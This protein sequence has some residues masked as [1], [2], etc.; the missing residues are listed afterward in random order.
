MKNLLL[1]FYLFIFSVGNSQNKSIDSLKLLLKIA[2]EDTNKCILLEK[3]CYKVRSTSPIEA[4]NYANEQLKLARELGYKKNEG[5]ALASI[6]RFYF[7]EG[8]YNKALFYFM[9]CLKIAEQLG[10]KYKI[11]ACYANIASVLGTNKEYEKALFY[12]EKNLEYLKAIKYKPGIAQGY[13]NIGLI[14]KELQNH[15]KALDYYLKSIDLCREIKENYLLQNNYEN[16]GA[17]YEEQDKPDLAIIY[18]DEA[19]KLSYSIEDYFCISSSYLNLGRIYNQLKSYQRSIILLDSS[20][21]YSL[22]SN[23]KETEFNAS[24]L[25]ANSYSGLNN[26]QAESKYLKKAFVLKDSL[27]NAEKSKQISEL[28]I[29]YETEKKEAEIRSLNAQNQMQSLKLEQRNYLLSGLAILFIFFILL[30][31]LLFRQNKLRSE[32]KSMQL[33]QKLLRSQMNPHFIFNALIAIESFI[34][35]NQPKEAG[36]YLSGFARLMRLILENSREEFVPLEKEISTLEYYLNLQKLRFDS[37]FDYSIK[38]DESIDPSTIAI[39][40]ML[41]QPF[42]E[43]SIEHGLKG[44]TAKGKI[45]IAFSLENN[46]LVFTVEDNGVGFEQSVQLKEQNI[47]HKSFA[48]KI[49]NERLHNLGRKSRRKIKLVTED[50]KDDLQNVVGGKVIFSI[51]FQQV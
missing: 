29:R 18:F 45:N 42:I 49:T 19:L 43:N 8:N 38:V 26:I 51:P 15:K 17:L 9:E 12:Y 22:L 41:A 37:T 24:L 11:A 14:Y 39:P 10:N 25:L 6:G 32:Q 48:T 27:F 31:F 23:N 2:R 21:K 7:Q 1:C 5:S 50:I 35:K 13:S 44:N 28:T 16:I 40:P 30:A 46:Q 34:Y 20:V 47:L 36:R 33:E 3:I 4:L